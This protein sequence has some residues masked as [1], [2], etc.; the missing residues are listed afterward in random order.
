[1]IFEQTPGKGDGCP[2]DDL[3]EGDE[4]EAKAKPK[5]AAKWRD[6]LDRSHSYSPL[7]LCYKKSGK[8]AKW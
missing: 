6:E 8:N 1:M 7:H 4:A 5:E 3:K 2:V